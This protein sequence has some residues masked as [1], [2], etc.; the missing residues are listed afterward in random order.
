MERLKDILTIE[1]LGMVK[2]RIEEKLEEL[3]QDQKEC[4]DKIDPLNTSKADLQSYQNRHL[5]RVDYILLATV[6]L[7]IIYNYRPYFGTHGCSCRSCD[8]A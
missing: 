1:S 8:C 5:E 6:I 4:K 2:S 3:Q 7:A